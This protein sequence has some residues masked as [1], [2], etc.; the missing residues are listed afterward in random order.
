M[1]LVGSALIRLS[2]TFHRLWPNFPAILIGQLWPVRQNEPRADTLGAFPGARDLVVC[3]VPAD[4]RFL[5]SQLAQPIIRCG[6]QSLQV[7]CLGIL[8]SVLGYFVFAEW[9][10]S[11]SAQLAVNTAGFALMIGAGALI[12]WYR[13]IDRDKA[14][15]AAEAIP[16][17][18]RLTPDQRRWPA[19]VPA[20]A[21]TPGS[22]KRSFGQ[23]W[24]NGRTLLTRRRKH[25][26]GTPTVAVHVPERGTAFRSRRPCRS[27][28]G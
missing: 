28:T 21:P 1:L 3:F 12:T 14:A 18:T 8:L 19:S 9:S 2:W 23:G 6:Q 17:I 24:T 20:D 15:V 4:A 10:S 7:F 27:C 5:R 16:V 22:A 13:T 26:D 25:S 11:L